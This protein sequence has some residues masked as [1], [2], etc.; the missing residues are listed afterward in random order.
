MISQQK[1]SIQGFNFLSVKLYEHGYFPSLM[2]TGK[3]N[4][5]NFLVYEVNV[6]QKEFCAFDEDN[7]TGLIF[8]WASFTRLNPRQLLASNDICDDHV[9]WTKQYWKKLAING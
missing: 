4:S 1:K 3:K 7:I 6:H 5:E 9:S 2:Q 8:S